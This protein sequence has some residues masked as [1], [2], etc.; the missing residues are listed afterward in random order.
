[1]GDVAKILLSLEK[2]KTLGFEPKVSFEE[3]VQRYV[4]WMQQYFTQ[5]SFPKTH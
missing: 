3:G 4:Q 2:I 5:H 1:V